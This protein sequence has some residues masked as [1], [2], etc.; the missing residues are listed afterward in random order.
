M[1]GKAIRHR[2]SLRRVA[3]VVGA[4]DGTTSAIKASTSS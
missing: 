4:S 2:E 1:D 3:F